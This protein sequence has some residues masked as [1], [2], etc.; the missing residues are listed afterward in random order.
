M[1]RALLPIAVN[2]GTLYWLGV[3]ALVA[4]IFYLM[5]KATA[6][7]RI[8]RA[9]LTNDIASC[10]SHNLSEARKQG[11]S[12]YAAAAT[13]GLLVCRETTFAA[14]LA[15]EQIIR[16]E[17]YVLQ[18]DQN[19]VMLLLVVIITIA[20]VVLAALQLL[21]SF[22]IAQAGRAA[23]AQATEFSVKS[24][25]FSLKSSY[26]G[27]VILGLSLL[28]FVVFVLFVY[29]IE[30]A[31]TGRRPEPNLGLMMTPGPTK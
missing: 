29:R 3:C 27:V 21:A 23:M 20:G 26:V 16:N 28:F 11:A 24:S 13:N 14:L 6:T 25:E 5:G 18:R 17:T 19:S 9:S 31:S 1:T 10:V 22:Y 30:G 7:P 12:L 8:T 2:R 15:D 4:M